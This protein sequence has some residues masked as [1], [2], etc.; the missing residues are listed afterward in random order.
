MKRKFNDT[1]FCENKRARSDR[2]NKR[3]FESQESGPNKRLNP[4]VEHLEKENQHL[5]TT[6]EHAA[7][8]NEM[9]KDACFQA[10]ERI[11]HLET[12][13]TIQRT[14][15]DRFRVNNNITVY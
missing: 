3:K 9:M 13:L 7:K 5:K 15:M 2:T 4:Y 14:Q 8:E 6:L 10:A 1:E 12:L 11:A